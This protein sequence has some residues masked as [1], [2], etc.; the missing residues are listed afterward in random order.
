MAPSVAA[1]YNSVAKE[2][3][4]LTEADIQGSPIRIDSKGY[5]TLEH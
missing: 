4:R 5:I 3:K 1:R 2:I